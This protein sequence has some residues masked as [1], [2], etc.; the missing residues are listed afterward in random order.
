MDQIDEY[1]QGERV[2]AWLR[3]N[4]SSLIG[5]VALGLACLGGWQWWQGQQAN[6]K[7][8]A[9]I[10]F[11]AF[12]K[13]LRN[14]RAVNGKSLQGQIEALTRVQ[15]QDPAIFS[16]QR[17]QRILEHLIEVIVPQLGADSQQQALGA[18]V[19]ADDAQRT[20]VELEGG[21]HGQGWRSQVLIDKA[22][23]FGVVTER[24]LVILDQEHDTPKGLG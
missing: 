13:A 9:A 20:E 16:A 1:E 14:R 18:I 12:D 21:G 6:E 17:T 19:A 24:D 11:S 4:G 22:L 7:V 5:G 23:Y 2:R 3:N 8:Q 15:V 10:E